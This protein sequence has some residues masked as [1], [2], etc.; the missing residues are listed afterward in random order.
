MCIKLGEDV[1]FTTINILIYQAHANIVL[2]NNN[3][4]KNLVAKAGQLST[5][6]M[7]HSTYTKI[8]GYFQMTEVEVATAFYNV[9]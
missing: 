9:S 8:K 2:H 7:M 4:H 5:H 6:D 3:M 1:L